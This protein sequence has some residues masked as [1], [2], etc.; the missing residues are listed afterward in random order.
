MTFSKIGI[1]TLPAIL[2]I[3][4]SS[5]P[6]DAVAN[7]YDALKEGDVVKLANNTA[8]TMSISLMSESLK[9]CSIDKK[10]YKDQINLTNDCLKEK[11]KNIS[12][13]DIKITD[14]SKNKA[15]AE[16]AVIQNNNE[17]LITFAVEKIDGKWMVS[18]RK[19]Q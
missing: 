16:V 4:C 3:G 11:Y 17:I 10:N 2:F 12:Y 14:V 8:E 18:G 9:D 1:L 5:T 6:K 19:R 7:M 15:Y 13:K